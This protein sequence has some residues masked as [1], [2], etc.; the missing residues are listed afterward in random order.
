MSGAKK[1]VAGRLSQTKTKGEVF[2]REMDEAF[3]GDNY[4]KED[5]LESEE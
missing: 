1:I 2:L 3:T 5:G 4:A